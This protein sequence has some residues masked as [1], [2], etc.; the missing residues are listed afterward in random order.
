MVLI[1]FIHDV[2]E[3]VQAPHI[4][5]R[6]AHDLNDS[7]TRL[8]PER[9]GQ[10]DHDQDDASDD[11]AIFEDKDTWTVESTKEGYLQAIDGESLIELAKQHDLVIQLRVRP[12]RFMMEGD[13]IALV[14]A[15]V[16]DEASFVD[17]VDD[18]LIV[19][20]MR[21]PLQDVNCAIL[22]LAQLAVRA[23]SP[24]INDPFTAMN[25]IDRLSAALGRLVQRKLPSRDRCDQ[26]GQLRVIADRV[27]F[28]EALAAA[29]NQIRQNAADAPPVGVRL[30]EGLESLGRKARR[31]SDRQA[32]LEQAQMILDTFRGA[33]MLDGDRQGIEDQFARVR[34]VVKQSRKER[35]NTTG[36]SESDHVRSGQQP[37]SS[38]RTPARQPPEKGDVNG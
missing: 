37:G 28:G 4:V 19:G 26:D 11:S 24:G 13:P 34:A 6:L 31:E 8:F 21:T 5:A 7:I 27:T 30:L 16:D 1:Y 35:S 2:A 29:F 15:K 25:G 12:G 10:F 38:S 18:A 36:E 33:D 23:L 3:A 22:E 14:S 9:I 20:E 32:I 17:A